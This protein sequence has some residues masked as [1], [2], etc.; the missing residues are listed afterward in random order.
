MKHSSVNFYCSGTYQFRHM[1]DLPVAS[2]VI[3][4]VCVCQFNELEQEEMGWD[5]V[6][7]GQ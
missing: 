3:G 6:R 2:Q 5:W 7:E 4:C 1:A